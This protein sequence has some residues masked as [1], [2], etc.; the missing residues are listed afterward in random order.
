MD[1]LVKYAIEMRHLSAAPNETIQI[2]FHR[3]RSSM[4]INTGISMD[5]FI[6]SKRF[7]IQNFSF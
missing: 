4:V 2:D 1:P 3:Q 5:V 7:S 6:N